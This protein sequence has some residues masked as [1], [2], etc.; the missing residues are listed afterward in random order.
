MEVEKDKGRV[1]AVLTVAES[2]DALTNKVGFDN[3]LRAVAGLIDQ[4]CIEAGEKGQPCPDA[5]L[6]EFGKAST[7][8][9]V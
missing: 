2:V 6:I 8:R 5:I 7:F 1:V 4:V 9:W 3:S